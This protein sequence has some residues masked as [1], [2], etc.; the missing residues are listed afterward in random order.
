LRDTSLAYPVRYQDQTSQEARNHAV[1]KL[2][3][4]LT[5]SRVCLTVI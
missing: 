3:F 5:L 2:F 1:F 4:T